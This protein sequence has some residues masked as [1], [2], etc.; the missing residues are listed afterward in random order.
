MLTSPEAQGTF[1][2]NVSEMIQGQWLRAFT[3]YLC[4]REAKVFSNE[5]FS[6]WG[7]KNNASSTKCYLP[8]PYHLM[9]WGKN[10]LQFLVKGCV[11]I[12]QVIFSQHEIKDYEY[13]IRLNNKSGFWCQEFLF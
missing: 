6:I 13:F 1:F 4:A 12:F 10:D 8:N 2:I 11:V 9:L 3:M 5:F 7:K